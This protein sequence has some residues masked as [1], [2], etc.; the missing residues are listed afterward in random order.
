MSTQKAVRAC[1]YTQPSLLFISTQCV[2]SR[3]C[4]NKDLLLNTEQTTLICYL[5]TPLNST[6]FSWVHVDHTWVPLGLSLGTAQPGAHSEPGGRLGWAEPVCHLGGPQGSTGSLTTA[7]AAS[8]GGKA[9]SQ[10]CTRRPGCRSS[11]SP[12]SLCTSAAPVA[13]GPATTQVGMHCQERQQSSGQDP[14]S[15]GSILGQCVH[16]GGGD[17]S[18]QQVWPKACCVSQAH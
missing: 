3:R 13:Q 17:Q 7:L 4:S 15:S 8:W 5:K 14:H 11:S 10:W 6:L 9:G 12:L 16:L 1:L 18:D 2:L